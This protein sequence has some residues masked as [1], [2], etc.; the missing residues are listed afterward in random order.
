VR[1]RVGVEVA[2]LR[3]FDKTCTQVESFGTSGLAERE[4]L[5][6]RD[7][8]SSFQIHGQND[9]FSTR[10]VPSVRN[11]LSA[12][13]IDSSS[14]ALGQAGKPRRNRPRLT[15]IRFFGE[16]KGLPASNRMHCLQARVPIPPSCIPETARL[17]RLPLP[18]STALNGRGVCSSH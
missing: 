10:R 13:Y 17:S 15:E 18:A 11:E 12:W 16:H 2:V 14:K 3:T 1:F 5:Q 6:T 7:S 4:G 8:A 9:S